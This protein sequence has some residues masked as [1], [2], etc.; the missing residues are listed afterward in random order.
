MAWG[1]INGARALHLM[2]ENYYTKWLKNAGMFVLL[3]IPPIDP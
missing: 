3:R 1:F 2:F